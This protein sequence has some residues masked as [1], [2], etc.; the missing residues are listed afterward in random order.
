M[1]DLLIKKSKIHGKGVFAGRNFK[2]GEVVLKWDLDTTIARKDIP[3]LPPKIRKNI[4]F[5]KGKYIVPSSPGIY[6]NHSC[7]ANTIA[8]NASDIA[9]KDILKGEEITIDMSKEKIVGLNMKCRCGSK[10]CKGTIRSDIRIR[11]G[12]TTHKSD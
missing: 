9:K 7:E 10:H 6:L 5:Y 3:K 1:T 2:K 8:K 11:S 12:K 4:Y